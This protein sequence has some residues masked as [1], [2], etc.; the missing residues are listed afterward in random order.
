MQNAVQDYKSLF[1]LDL[2][3]FLDMMAHRQLEM[4]YQEWV[5]MVNRIATGI[6]S[7]PAQYLGS[8]LPKPE[9]TSKVIKEIFDAF[10]QENSMAEDSVSI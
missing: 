6:E 9:I 4:D 5:E 10:V 1:S 3:P 8:N 7:N 2:M